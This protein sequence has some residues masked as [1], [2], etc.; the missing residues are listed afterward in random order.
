MVESYANSIEDRLVDGLSFK[1]EPGASY[2]HERK[3]VSFH[4]QGSSVYSPTQGTNL[5][6]Q[7]F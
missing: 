3:S 2:I 6:K 1:I 5:L 7:I 4:P